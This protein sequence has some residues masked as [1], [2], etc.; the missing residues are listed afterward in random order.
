MNT[1]LNYSA[2]RR[3][4][5][6][7]AA[8][9]TDYYTR[10]LKNGG[11]DD[12]TRAKFAEMDDATGAAAAQTRMNATSPGMFGQGAA[13][14]AGQIADN[15]VMQ[16]VASNKLKQAQ[17]GGEAQ[18]QAIAGAAGWQGQQTAEKNADRD[19]SYKAASDLGDAVTMGGMARSSLDQQGYG[20][21]DYGE[22]QLTSQADQSKADADWARQQQREQ[23]ERQ[24]R[25]MDNQ[26]S[27]SKPKAWYEKLGDSVMGMAGTAASAGMGGFSG[28]AAGA[29]A[30]K[31]FGG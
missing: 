24:K 22:K 7:L 18:Q 9:V 2:G 27:A 11:I 10:R 1:V 16:Q 29:L 14:R 21:T 3:Q 17:L 31:Y 20:Y 8:G 5:N 26:I 4:T 6:P 19:F 23:W 15:S 25:L 28:T 13:S 12:A 30:K